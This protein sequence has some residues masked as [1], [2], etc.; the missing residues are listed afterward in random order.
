MREAPQ[1]SWV[2]RSDNLSVRE[3]EPPTPALEVAVFGVA[4]YR[5]HRP[6]AGAG[7]TPPPR[8]RGWLGRGVDAL[9][10]PLEVTFIV[11]LSFL[12]KAGASRAE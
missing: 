6:G 11:S 1:S 3:N 10:W 8:K 4:V 12:G 5:D 7:L 9:V 2:R